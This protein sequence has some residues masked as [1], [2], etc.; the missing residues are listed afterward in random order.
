M[1]NFVKCFVNRLPQWTVTG[2]FGL[3]QDLNLKDFLKSM[4]DD[5]RQN[6]RF[7]I[8]GFELIKNGFSFIVRRFLEINGRKMSTTSKFYAKQ[9]NNDGLK[10]EEGVCETLL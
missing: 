3:N 7:E 5:H 2:E 9:R 4:V 1:S 8:E 10:I 6:P